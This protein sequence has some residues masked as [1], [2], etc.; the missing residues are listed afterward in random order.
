MLS[1]LRHEYSHAAT[2]KSIRERAT[3]GVDVVSFLPP[4]KYGAA[5]NKATKEHLSKI[6]TDMLYVV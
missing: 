6:P 2:Y 5:L 4:I 3:N 1:S